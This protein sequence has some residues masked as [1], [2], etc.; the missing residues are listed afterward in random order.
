MN[1]QEQF[2]AARD[3]DYAA[4]V[5][6]PD[7]K[8]EWPS[9]L[10]RDGYYGFYLLAKFAGMLLQ[11]KLYTDEDM[12]K[13]QRYPELAKSYLE[14]G[15][16]FSPRNPFKKK[17]SYMLQIVDFFNKYLT[18]TQDSEDY[19]G[20]VDSLIER[21]ESARM[22]MNKLRNA[23][24]FLAKQWCRILP[25]FF[26]MQGECETENN[27]FM[28]QREL[29]ILRKR[30]LPAPYIAWLDFSVRFRKFAADQA[31]GKMI[32]LAEEWENQSAAYPEYHNPFE[33]EMLTLERF[34]WQKDYMIALEWLELLR[35]RNPDNLNFIK[36][37][38]RFL[39]EDNQMEKAQKLC[40]FTL[41]KF[42]PDGE[43]FC[44]S[45]NLAFLLGDYDKAREDGQSAALLAESMPACHVAL[46]Y[47]AMYQDDLDI[48]LSS[49]ET[50]L[51]LDDNNTDAYRG[52]AKVLFTAGSTFP[53]L[54]CLQKFFRKNPHC[55]DVCY[56]LADMYFLAGYMKEA[57]AYC[58]KCLEI[59]REFS[60][61]YI[62]LGMMDSRGAKDESAA[63]W[64]NKALE[65]DPSNPVALYELAFLEHLAGNDEKSMEMLERTMELAPEYADP[66][67]SMGVIQFFQ[68][69]F[70]EALAS[71]DRA[72]DMDPFHLG[73][74]V[75]KGNIYLALSDPQ[76]ALAWY[77][78]A[79]EEEPYYAEAIHGKINAY[80]SLGLEQEAFEWMEKIK[81]IGDS[82]Y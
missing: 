12:S 69:L 18:A 63:E 38:I 77:D 79:L 57:R 49:F 19:F 33:F 54:C 45:S 9:A 10:P 4:L 66:V 29:N 40:E 48:A 81:D 53:A 15:T 37:E 70:D 14:S 80:R 56:D 58:L 52:K 23:D 78:M 67:Y 71:M 42:P 61:A 25:V 64:L 36:W 41:G 73:A 16:A 35:L 46:G 55:I 24:L 32:I 51:S 11:S 44:F 6:S 7:S 60:N 43:L 68:C 65:L 72:L 47:A 17:P 34:Y 62:L 30:G 76:E 75:G 22:S 3:Y 28:W 21:V 5:F 31:V 1:E 2:A 59:D 8:Q 74:L 13:Y 50:A 39:R 27:S 26:Y 82:E 20:E